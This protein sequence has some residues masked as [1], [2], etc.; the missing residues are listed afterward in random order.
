MIGN[1]WQDAYQVVRDVAGASLKVMIGDA[2]LGVGVRLSV[3]VFVFGVVLSSKFLR[4]TGTA[5]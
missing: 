5:S 2:F 4:R 3:L 1:Y